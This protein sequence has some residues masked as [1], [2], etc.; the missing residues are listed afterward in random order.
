MDIV[1]PSFGSFSL[2]VSFSRRLC[3]LFNL[4]RITTLTHLPKGPV[5]ITSDATRF[6]TLTTSGLCILEICRVVLSAGKVVHILQV[7]SAQKMFS[8]ILFFMFIRLG[9]CFIFPIIG[10]TKWSLNPFLSHF[11]FRFNHPEV[12]YCQIPEIDLIRFCHCA[13]Q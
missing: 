2:P 3:T 9:S 4:A 11:D 7:S 8:P 12:V 13:N 6:L 10:C 5:P 1:C